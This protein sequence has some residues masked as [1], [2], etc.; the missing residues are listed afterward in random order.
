MHCATVQAFKDRGK[1]TA[2]DVWIQYLFFL[3]LYAS[4]SE[5]MQVT[6]SPTARL[7]HAQ[8]VSVFVNVHENGFGQEASCSAGNFVVPFTSRH[9]HGTQC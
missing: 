6:A 3:S 4:A 1:E 7:T 5:C 8:F 2:E 9:G